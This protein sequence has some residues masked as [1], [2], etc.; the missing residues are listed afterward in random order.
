MKTLTLHV[1]EKSLFLFHNQ[2]TFIVRVPAKISKAE[3]KTLVEND[4][5]VKVD[6]VRVLNQ[7]GKTK[8]YRGVVFG[9]R[10]K[11][12]HQSQKSNFKKA[13]IVLSKG[14]DLKKI[15]PKIGF[16]E[17]ML[18]GLARNNGDDYN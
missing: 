6:K 11:K 12:I 1:T 5:E 9:S 14:Q 3:I 13:Y 18:R 4:L 7:R 2:E 10:L 8:R 16:D 15:A 17:K